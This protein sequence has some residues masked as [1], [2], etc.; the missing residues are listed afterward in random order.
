MS[1]LIENNQQPAKLFKTKSSEFAGIDD[2]PN[3][4]IDE[5]V[6]IRDF[7]KLML[8]PDLAAEVIEAHN[9]K[10]I[11]HAKNPFCPVDVVRGGR[12]YHGE[13]VG[14]E[15]LFTAPSLFDNTVDTISATAREDGSFRSLMYNVDQQSKIAQHFGDEI[16]NQFLG[17]LT[18]RDLK[19]N[20]V[21]AARW[22]HIFEYYGITDKVVKAQ[23]GKDFTPGPTTG[24][25]SHDAQNYDED[26]DA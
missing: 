25:T 19:V 9:L 14:G 2:I 4:R 6:F 15:V 20:P 5:D 7:L 11:H 10:W 1:D 24:S 23:T 26:E 12:M 8:E 22:I 16:L 13:L 18:N 17:G 3:P 21:I